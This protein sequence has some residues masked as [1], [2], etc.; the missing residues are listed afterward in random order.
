MNASI[1]QCPDAPGA[2][3]WY[4]PDASAC[5]PAARLAAHAP[6]WVFIGMLAA[7]LAATLAAVVARSAQ[8]FKRLVYPAV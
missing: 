4:D 7:A 6:F 3:S 1:V 8:R 2:G 5:A